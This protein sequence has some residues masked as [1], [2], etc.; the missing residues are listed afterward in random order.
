MS[1]LFI[2]ESLEAEKYVTYNKYIKL[3]L[4]MIFI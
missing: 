2:S 1:D 4:L 3:L